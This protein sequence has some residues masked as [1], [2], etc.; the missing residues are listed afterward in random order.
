[1]QISP[2]P[3]FSPSY[4]RV[5]LLH[6]AR[7]SI[8]PIYRT[9]PTAHFRDEIQSLNGIPS[10]ALP[11]FQ[12]SFIPQRPL[13][14]ALPTTSSTKTMSMSVPRSSRRQV[15]TP[16]RSVVSAE[17]LR[18]SLSS[19]TKS[20]STSMSPTGVAIPAKSPFSPNESKPNL[21][22]ACLQNGNYPRNVTPHPDSCLLHTPQ[23]SASKLKSGSLEPPPVRLR[24]SP[25]PDISP[26][27]LPPLRLPPAYPKPKPHVR[28]TTIT[29]S[30]AQRVLK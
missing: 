5:F 23:S 20:M 3:F 12:L 29:T 10:H 26:D 27:E 9:V 13:P 30:A 7:W 19:H 11:T 16:S 18:H 22:N 24:P 8:T 25:S 21:R 17:E 14:M 28:S 15:M 1:M 6:S 2:A 4:L